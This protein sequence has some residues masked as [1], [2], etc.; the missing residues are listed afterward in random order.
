MRNPPRLALTL[1]AGLGLLLPAVGAFAGQQTVTFNWYGG[2]SNDLA[3]GTCTYNFPDERPFAVP[4]TLVVDS[5]TPDG[6]EIFSWGYGQ[7]FSDL[8]ISCTGSGTENSYNHI[9]PAGTTG[10]NQP[11]MSFIMPG[12]GALGQITSNSGVKLK[13]FARFNN[14]CSDAYSSVWSPS[15]SCPATGVDYELTGLSAERAVQSIIT[16]ASSAPGMADNQYQL[17]STSGSLSLRAVLVKEGTLEYGS[18]SLTPGSYQLTARGASESTD[19][20]TGSGIQI[21]PP[22]CQLKT[23]D[24]SIPMGSW[25]ADLLSWTGG[26]TAYG[27]PVAVNL[28]LE[29]SGSVDHVRFRFADAGT[30]TSANNN[31]TLYDTGGSKIDGL[32]IEMCYNGNKVN[33]DN[34]TETDTGSHG[35]AKSEPQALPE[36]DSTSTVAFQARYFQSGAI[37]RSGADY[38]G[39]VAGKVN[40]FVTYD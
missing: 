16:T 3:A 37:T 21:V 17:S 26:S 29:C 7:L 14:A 27:S 10:D 31:V 19:L 9:T 12:G 34:V 32:E 24:Y 5:N 39:Q 15:T 18:L 20:F 35:T 30:A 22:A 38:T 4:R 33:I 1:A 25:A 13:L 40:M 8:T 6:T 36:F 28:S 2:N 23:K 11:E